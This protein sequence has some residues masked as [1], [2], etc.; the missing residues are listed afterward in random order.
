MKLIDLLEIVRVELDDTEAPYLWTDTELLDAAADAENEACRRARLLIDSSTPA[1]CEIAVTAGEP[2]YELD[3]RVLFVRRAKLDG[4]D[5][6]LR[7]ASFRDLDT[8]VSGWESHTGDPT[9]YITDYETGKIRFYP[10]PVV[11]DVLRITAVRLPINE[12]SDQEQTPE[13]KP[14]YHRSL[15]F[16]MMF[17]AYSKP[18]TETLDKTKAAESLALFEQEFGPKS[19]AIDEEW[20]ER[21]QAADPYDG[22]F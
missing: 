15:R 16:W 8:N 13:I 2:L 12:I 22:T 4:S 11:D 19:A 18:D 17:R 6:P 9:H 7:R 3:S 5:V 21:E 1:I 14:H 10:T 20:I